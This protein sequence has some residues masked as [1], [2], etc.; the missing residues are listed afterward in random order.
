MGLAPWADAW[1]RAEAEA[2][3]GASTSAPGDAQ[4]V[5]LSD[6]RSTPPPATRSPGSRAGGA[7]PPLTYGRLDGTGGDAL[8]LNWDQMRDLPDPGGW[9]RLPPYSQRH[10]DHPASA[11]QQA[12]LRHA[13]LA[14]RVQVDLEEQV[15]AFLSRLKVRTRAVSLGFAGGVALN[16]VL[17]GRISRELGFAS[18]YVPP[19][20]GDEGIAL[21]CAAFALHV[22][23]TQASNTAVDTLAGGDAAPLASTE[24]QGDTSR[25]V[26]GQVL[27]QLSEQASKQ[28]SDQ[29]LGQ[30]SKQSSDQDLGQIS[31]Q[32]SDQDLGQA[33]VGSSLVMAVLG[34]MQ[35][36]CPPSFP[37]ASCTSGPYLGGDITA[38]EVEAAIEELDS[39][40]QIV[41]PSSLTGDETD[42]QATGAAAVQGRR[43]DGLA[44]RG[45]SKRPTKG[46]ARRARAEKGESSAG[47]LAPPPVFP[48]G[49]SQGSQADAAA[50]SV[51]R[52]LVAALVAGEV[53]GICRG[54]SEVGPRALGHRSIL[55]DPR[56]A[57]MHTRANVIKQR[58]LFR[59]LAPAVLA[60]QASAWFDSVDEDAS[61]YMSITA[62]VRGEVAAQI[63]AV[64]H[65]DGS[66]RLQTVDERR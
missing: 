39:W 49:S 18:F 58:E 3:R 47:R 32:S 12:R 1:G 45:S 6:G 41:P 10:M 43:A 36:L 14:A 2:T 23:S 25:Q 34:S 59:P 60:E 38:S 55:A 56:R 19:W 52:A 40:V 50:H 53:V 7:L 13:R 51:V 46:R 26:S 44:A 16:S 57:E 33:S 61:P 63:P 27:G 17:N 8:R 29:D 15:L 35:S 37:L 9:R 48:Q 28:S 65:V 5:S 24:L 21:G 4:K 54:R 22:A 64:T 20:P 42:D 11:D 30:I 62:F 66:A 31:K